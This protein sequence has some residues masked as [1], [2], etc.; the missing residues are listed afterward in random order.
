MKKSG[1]GE[2]FISIVDQSGS[3][4]INRS[5]MYF[6]MLVVHINKKKVLKELVK[7]KS[8]DIPS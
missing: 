2:S 6:Q 5:P 4:R 7:K 3:N 1:I 8:N